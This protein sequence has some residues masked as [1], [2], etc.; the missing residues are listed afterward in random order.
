MRLHPRAVALA[1]AVHV[2]PT[3]T[4][5]P[6]TQLEQPCPLDVSLYWHPCSEIALTVQ[7]RN[8]MCT[9]DRSH[10]NAEMIPLR[11]LG[12]F[13]GAASFVERTTWHSSFTMQWPLLA[14]KLEF[15]PRWKRGRKPKTWEQMNKG[16]LWQW[17]TQ[18]CL[19]TSKTNAYSGEGL[20]L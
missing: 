6:T 11:L 4:N 9:D 19:S 20:K 12:F 15:A 17:L 8:L 2:T 13:L 1:V 18:A 7:Y 5:N 3:G 16:Q 14:W 10:R